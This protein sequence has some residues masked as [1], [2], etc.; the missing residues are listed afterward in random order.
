M[1]ALFQAERTHQSDEP[2]LKKTS[3]TPLGKT[4]LISCSAP[5]VADMRVSEK[6]AVMQERAVGS[7]SSVPAALHGSE[8]IHM[9]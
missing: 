3:M 8:V 5:T 9:S 7:E 1:S 4:S 6:A 2:Y